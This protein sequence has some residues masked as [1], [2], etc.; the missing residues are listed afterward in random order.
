VCWGYENREA[1]L[2][3]CCPRGGISSVN[4]EFKS[5]DGSTNPHIG[6]AA[7]LVAGMQGVLGE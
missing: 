3:V 5:F 1:P 2:R 7:V 4:A 6:L